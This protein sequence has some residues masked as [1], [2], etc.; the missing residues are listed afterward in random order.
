M[1]YQHFSDAG[2]FI[3]HEGIR[4]FPRADTVYHIATVLGM[5]SAQFVQYFPDVRELHNS[6]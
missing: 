4:E 1:F 6:E 3:E 2:N 5:E